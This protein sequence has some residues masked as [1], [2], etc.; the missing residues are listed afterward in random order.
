MFT[1]AQF[2]R[3]SSVAVAALAVAPDALSKA[4]DGV[5][6]VKKV[7]TASRTQWNA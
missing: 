3:L 5:V 6:R 7:P 4:N 2:L 1:R